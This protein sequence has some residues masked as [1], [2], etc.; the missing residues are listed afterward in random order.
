[1]YFLAA[2]AIVLC[3]SS[4][5]FY[6]ATSAHIDSTFTSELQGVRNAL[7]AAAEVEETEVKWQPLEHSINLN[8]LDEFGEVDWVVLGDDDQIVEQ[9]R[10]GTQAIP[11][12][13]FQTWLEVV[14]LKDGAVQETTDGWAVVGQRLAA[15]HPNRLERELDEFDQLTI[16]AARPTSTRNAVLFRLTLLVT[17]LPML[18]WSVAA[19]LGR[20]VV[21]KALRPVAD[22]AHQAQTFSGTDFQSRLEYRDS[23]DELSELG[24]AFN[25]LLERQQTAF[26]QQRRFAG[27]AAHE[28]RTP[29]TVLLGNIDVTLRRPRSEAEYQSNLE[30]LRYQTRRLQEI[31][32]AL[33]FLARSDEDTVK[34]TLETMSLGLWLSEH[35]ATWASL[36]RAADLQISND[37]QDSIRVRATSALL[38]RIVD[39]LVSNAL[40]YSPAGTPVTVQATADGT[41]CSVRV[42][43]EG[44]GISEDDQQHLFAPFFR[45]T[46]MRK[47]GI[48][49][50]G[51]GLAIANR[52][53]KTLGGTLEV[54]SEPGRGSCFELRLPIT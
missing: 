5:V 3:A 2:L 40:K 42:T 24:A 17:L 6:L 18:V 39:N 9:S 22:M 43:D 49:G 32:E 25:R 36:S 20:L 29:L 34:P 33:L 37:V 41:S 19:L 35:S 45:S 10:L 15:P 13:V 46:E 38:A 47:K 23:G 27:D 31:V 44:D 4:M 7:V 30:S 51:L 14:D 50:N 53:A 8:T 52:I 12:S 21:R 26:E 48:A 16:V 54:T 11:P 1:M 28:L